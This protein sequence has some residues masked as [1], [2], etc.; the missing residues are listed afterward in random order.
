MHVYIL[1][2]VSNFIGFLLSCVNN[3]F[4]FTYESWEEKEAD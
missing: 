1:L 3:A 4:A 2:I